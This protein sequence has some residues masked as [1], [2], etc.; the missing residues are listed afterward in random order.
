MHFS[1]LFLIA[2]LPIVWAA[3]SC[4]LA[5]APAPVPSTPASG[6]L[7]TGGDNSSIVA[8]AWYPGWMTAEFPISQ[9]SWDKY[10]MLTYSFAETTPDVNTLN[11]ANSDEPSV[12]TF[13]D[14]A[15]QN[16]VLA[17]VSIGGWTGSIHFSTNVATAE[18][19]AAFVKTVLG[20]VSKYNLDGIDFDW[21]YPNHQGIGCNT[22][23]EDDSA[24][25]LSFLQE[26]RKDETGKKL[27]LTA[28]TSITPFAGPDGTPMTDVSEFAKVLNYVAIMNY[29]LNGQWSTV[30]GPNAPLADECST[31]KA[32]SAT[33]AIA[34]WTEAK[35]PASQ[36]LLGVPAYGHSFSVKASDAV[37]SAGVLTLNAPFTKNTTAAPGVDQCGTPNVVPDG[38][39][40]VDLVKN[41]YLNTNGTAANGI[42][43]KFDECSQTPFV[44]N[45]ETQLM[46]SYDDATSF[47]AKGK[48]ILD[49]KL[50]GFAMWDATGDSEDIL[51]NSISEALGLSS[52]DC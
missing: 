5:S 6:G 33:E 39:N 20:L 22:I 45:P 32:G 23:S 25:F 36:L 3:P 7:N 15:H 9:I 49:N 10:S 26:L 27:M 8:A 28:A 30:V 16:N 42:Q 31:V 34:S 13:V 12:S 24:N 50:A 4:S 37:D 38:M 41:G 48:F 11:L 1:S 46:V 47:A 18:N 17:L 19:R 51:L 43:Y 2:S 21:E 14:A 40:F 29:D 35:F 44:Y 52:D